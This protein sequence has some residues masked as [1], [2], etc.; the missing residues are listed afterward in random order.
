MNKPKSIGFTL[1]ELM[2]VVSI[3]AMLSAI[4]Y[5]SFNSYMFRS[6]RADAQN[7]LTRVAAEQERHYSQ[8][9]RYALDLSAAPPAGL[10]MTLLTSEHGYYTVS[11]AAGPSGDNQTYA[12][13]ATAGGRQ[14]S[15]E[16]GNMS[17]NS[18][19][20]KTYSG[21]STNRACW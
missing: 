13:T 10:G 8:F 6:R 1:I 18:A 14:A 11:V 12:L 7:L 15:D 5:P 3:V 17:L 19:G 21:S 20:V 16:C 9:N 4:A 2:V